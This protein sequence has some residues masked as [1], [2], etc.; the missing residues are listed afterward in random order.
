MGMVMVMIVWWV[1]GM[2]RVVVVNAV[3]REVVRGAGIMR[4]RSRRLVVVSRSVAETCETNADR[5]VHVLDDFKRSVV[6]A[7][8]YH[9]RCHER[10]RAP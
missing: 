3:L 2:W 10:A 4:R 9:Q 6:S 8:S 7:Q 5:I 1:R